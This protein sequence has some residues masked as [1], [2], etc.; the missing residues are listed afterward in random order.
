MSKGEA[1]SVFLALKFSIL[2]YLSHTFA[3]MYFILAEVFFP[4]KTKVK[5]VSKNAKQHTLPGKRTG[6]L[7]D[8][9]RSF[10]P[11]WNYNLFNNSISV[12]LCG[13]SN[14]CLTLY[15]CCCC[16]CRSIATIFHAM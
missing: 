11:F 14:I 1:N 5:R 9:L 12:F 10:L 4:G 13:F 3:K 7:A 16:C 8:N 2:L 15:I 6:N